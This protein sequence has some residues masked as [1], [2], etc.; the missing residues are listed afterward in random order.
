VLS[1][2]LIDPTDAI[3]DLPALCLFDDGMTEE[4]LGQ[5]RVVPW[6][7]KIQ[8]FVSRAGELADAHAVCRDFRADLIDVLGSDI[9]LGGNCKNTLW[10]SPPKI[11][12]ISFQGTDYVGVDGVYRIR[13][14][15]GRNF[16]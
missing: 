13:F 4:R 1:T 11:A 10:Q 7:L 8:I 6:D 5:W 9:T 16:S 15:E 14:E 3:N 2:V 12:G